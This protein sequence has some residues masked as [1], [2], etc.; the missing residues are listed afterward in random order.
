MKRLSSIALAL[1]AL[2]LGTV[3]QASAADLPAMPVKAAPLLVPA[4]SWTGLYVGVHVGGGWSRARWDSDFNCAIGVL[5]ETANTSPSGWLGGGQLG[6]R[7]Q[8]AS[9]VIGAEVSGA[10]AN[11]KN[12]SGST[13]T[14][15]VNTCIGIPGGFDVRY[16]AK[17]NSLYTVTGQLGHTFDRALLYVKGGWA[18]GQV[19]RTSQD[20]LGVPA[21]TF[22]YVSRVRANGYTVG[23]GLEYMFYQNF[24]LGVEYDYVRLT[25]RATSGIAVSGTGAPAFPVNE[26][27]VRMDIHQ[28]VARLN[29][30]VWSGGLVP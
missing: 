2:S 28:V 3:Q 11:L 19:E 7:W 5:C 12:T 1:A 17:L 30:K 25:G 15:G 20:V 6:Y 22:S 13:C 10:F 16:T 4:W 23:T 18:G 8:F 24:S 27:S 21:A 29:W 14:P 26:S 9:W